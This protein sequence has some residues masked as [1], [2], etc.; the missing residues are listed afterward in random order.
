LLKQLDLRFDASAIE[1]KF[2]IKYRAPM[3]NVI[4]RELSAY[5]VLLRAIR[6]SVAD[7]LANIDG[8]YPRPLEIEALWNK[9]Q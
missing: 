6:E 7:L 5:A 9:I 3:N 4:N 1:K 2:P 8:K